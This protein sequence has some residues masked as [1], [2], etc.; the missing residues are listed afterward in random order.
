M[1]HEREAAHNEEQTKLKFIDFD[2]ASPQEILEW[3]CDKY[4][5]ICLA[6]SLEGG[7]CGLHTETK[8]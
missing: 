6:T 8:S 1:V 7:E 2:K 5:S 3:A 4:K